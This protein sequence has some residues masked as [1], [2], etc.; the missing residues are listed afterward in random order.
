MVSYLHL[1]LQILYWQYMVPMVIS[2]SGQLIIMIIQSS[3]LVHLVSIE[4]LK[5]IERLAIINWN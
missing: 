1:S 2:L 3:Q 4:I 5:G